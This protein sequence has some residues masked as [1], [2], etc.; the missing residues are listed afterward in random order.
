MG[1]IKQNI[2]K[3]NYILKMTI[4]NIKA[5]QVVFDKNKNLKKL[6]TNNNAASVDVT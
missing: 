2:N 4:C 1:V 3:K 6:T 5:Y